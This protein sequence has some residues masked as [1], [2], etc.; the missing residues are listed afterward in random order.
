MT[1]ILPRAVIQ[2]E[3][4]FIN[5]CYVRSFLMVMIYLQKSLFTWIYGIFYSILRTVCHAMFW[6]Y[7]CIYSVKNPFS[8]S[9]HL[10]FMCKLYYY[11]KSNVNKM[12]MNISINYT[13]ISNRIGLIYRCIDFSIGASSLMTSSLCRDKDWIAGSTFPQW[14]DFDGDERWFVIRKS[15]A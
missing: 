13:T 8:A 4:L 3:K 5:W 1:C 9:T 15:T 6:F 2:Y 14:T 11:S 12:C 10:P 7:V